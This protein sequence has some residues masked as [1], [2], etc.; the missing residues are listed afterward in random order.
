MNGLV[1]FLCAKQTLLGREW[2]RVSTSVRPVCA[3]V[4]LPACRCVLQCLSVDKW[5]SSLRQSDDAGGGAP[6][7]RVFLGTGTPLQWSA[8]QGDR[9][10]GGGIL[11]CYR[12]FLLSL[13]F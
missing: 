5:V 6:D 4:T 3:A 1:L 9:L 8:Q 12:G 11:A 13:H 10:V 2:C 7:F